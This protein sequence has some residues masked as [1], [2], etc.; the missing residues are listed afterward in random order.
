[1]KKFYWTSIVTF[2]FSIFAVQSVLAATTSLNDLPRTMGC[3]DSFQISAEAYSSTVGA[4]S[5]AQAVSQVDTKIDQFTSLLM[6]RCSGTLKVIADNYNPLQGECGGNL[7]LGYE[8][9][10]QRTVTCECASAVSATGT[11]VIN[12]APSIP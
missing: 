5:C 7:A 1:M 9:S 10:R 4:K 3:G 6:G 11:S 2:A 8:Y 12:S